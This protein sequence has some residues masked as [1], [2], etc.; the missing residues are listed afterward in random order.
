MLSS[1]ETSIKIFYLA[2]VIAKY[3]NGLL[4]CK[5]S[6]GPNEYSRKGFGLRFIVMYEIEIKKSLARMKEVAA[7]GQDAPS[8]ILNQ[9]LQGSLPAEYRP[10][11]PKD[12]TV[13]RAIQRERRKKIPEPRTIRSVLACSTSN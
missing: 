3:P 12:A 1:F 4:D 8:G 7:Q 10:Y 5:V 6:L 2:S 11:L 13:K 9:E